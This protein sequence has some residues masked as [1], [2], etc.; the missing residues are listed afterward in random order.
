MI[1]RPLR[2]CTLRA[3]TKD[4][5]LPRRFV[6]IGRMVEDKCVDKL[7]RAYQASTASKRESLA[8]E[9][10]RFRTDEVAPREQDG[11]K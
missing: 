6:F 3:F 7:A 1:I 2:R 10:L 9:L 5:P 11:V 8:A 4:E